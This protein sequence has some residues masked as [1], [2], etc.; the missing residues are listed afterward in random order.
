MRRVL[1]WLVWTVLLFWLWILLVG[2]WSRYELI[3]GAAAA[4]LGATAM[5]VVRAQ[6]LLRFRVEFRWSLRICRPLARVPPEFAILAV[7][8]VQQL[9]RPRHRV[10]AFRTVAFPAGGQGPTD[11]GRRAFGALGGSLAP[12][13][14]VV[15]ID[16]RAGEMLVHELSPER[17]S[18]RPI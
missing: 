4:A 14:V 17:A 12:N 2:E 10:G 5:E 16:R 18:E 6:E 7:V 1:A 11:R 3:G 8:F 9:V 13:T 15:A